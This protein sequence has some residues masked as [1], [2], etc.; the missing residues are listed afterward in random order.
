[1]S[2][3]KFTIAHA[4]TMRVSN[5]LHEK[6]ASLYVRKKLPW[7]AAVFSRLNPR[8]ASSD[9]FLSPM[10]AARAPEL[11]VEYQ[12]VEC[13]PPRLGQSVE[14]LIGQRKASDLLQV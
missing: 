9:F 4:E 10:L 3:F 7:D 5:E 2:W 1:V 13:E 12:A 8:D 6:W 11:V 14:L